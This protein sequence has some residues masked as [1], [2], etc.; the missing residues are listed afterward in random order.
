MT[1]IAHELVHY[2]MGHYVDREGSPEKEIEADEL[3]KSWGF[4][5]EKFKKEF[6]ING[7]EA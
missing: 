1:I 7:K 2:Q 4:D 6:P 3:A 5:V